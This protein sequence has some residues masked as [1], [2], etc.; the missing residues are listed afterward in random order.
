MCSG[1][2]K[3]LNNTNFSNTLT[4]IIKFKHKKENCLIFLE[5]IC[6]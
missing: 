6:P 4:G 3:F 1:L 5:E 2:T